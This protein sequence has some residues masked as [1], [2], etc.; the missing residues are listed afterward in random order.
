MKEIISQTLVWIDLE[1]TGLNPDTDT[2]LE[3]ATIIT[4]NNLEIIAKAPSI[5]I[6]QPDEV[7]ENMNPIVQEMHKKSGL[8]EDV[9]R[10]Q[11]TLADAENLMFSF[12]KQYCSPGIAPLCGNTIYMDRRFLRKYMPQINEYLYYRMI[13][14]TSLKEIARRWYSQVPAFEKKETHR[15]LEDIAESIE[16]LKYYREHL[17]IS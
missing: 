3:I 5:V 13:D 16:E 2:I 8:I 7:L 6:H 12:I 1:M 17:F 15:A 14:V 4:D 11:V 10:S 9:R